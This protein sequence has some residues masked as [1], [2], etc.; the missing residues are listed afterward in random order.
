VHRETKQ[1][2]HA[3]IETQT[4]VSLPL[5][6]TRSCLT[7]I[8]ADSMR[9]GWLFTTPGRGVRLR[10]LPRKAQ[11]W[12]LS[13]FDNSQ[14][15]KMRSEHAAAG[16]LPRFENSR[17]IEMSSE[18]SNHRLGWRPDGFRPRSLHGISEEY[19][20][21]FVFENGPPRDIGCPGTYP[22]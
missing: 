19:C 5:S 15:V 3:R 4:A 8:S 11:K 13:R 20:G 12:Q 10:V 7:R 21:R 14:N 22:S 17:N 2:E 16:I 9:F 6:P 18:T 1:R